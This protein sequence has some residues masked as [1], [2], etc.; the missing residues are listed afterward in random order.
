MSELFLFHESL[1]K[2]KYEQQLSR[3]YLK[4]PLRKYRKGEIILRSG[5][6]PNFVGFIKS[7]YIRGYTENFTGQELSIPLF[8]SFPYFTA[9]YAITGVAGKLNF[10]AVTPVEMWIV[11]TDDFLN[12]CQITPNVEISILTTAS[13]LLIDLA[14]I[15]SALLSG[16]ATTKV[17]VAINHLKRYNTNFPITHKLIGSLTGLTRETVS[18][19]MLKFEEMK[20]VRNVSRTIKVLNQTKLN[21]IIEQD[22][23]RLQTKNR[24]FI[25][26]RNQ[27]FYQLPKLPNAR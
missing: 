13:V 6:N 16:N 22:N 10:K 23:H 1:M 27:N 3:F 8:K 14:N 21:E 18:L 15:S 12:F 17:A 9:I 25:Y 11:P 24:E 20:I 7:G 5:E 4:Y 2:N 19:L 26:P